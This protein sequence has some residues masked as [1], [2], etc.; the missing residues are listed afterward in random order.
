MQGGEA[1]ADDAGGH[2]D[3]GPDDGA[4]IGA[5][6]VCLVD[7]EDGPNADDGGAADAVWRGG[8]LAVG[9]FEIDRGRTR[10]PEGKSP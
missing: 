8:G 9:L 3:G 7:I 5:G 1:G 6:D 4:H 2:L 10:R